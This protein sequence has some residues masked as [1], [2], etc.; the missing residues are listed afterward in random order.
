MTNAD[1]E[2]EKDSPTRTGGNLQ[3]RE[4]APPTQ[5]SSGNDTDPERTGGNLQTRE[6]APPLSPS[7]GSDDDQERGSSGG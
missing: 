3:T 6:S 2:T 5:P 1:N 4:S 7:S